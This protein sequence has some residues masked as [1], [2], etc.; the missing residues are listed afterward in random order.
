MRLIDLTG[1]TFGDLTVV[2][3]SA[4]MYGVEATWDCRCSCGAMIAVGGTRLRRGLT[5]HCGCKTQEKVQAPLTN[6]ERAAPRRRHITVQPG[7]Q[8]GALTV[9]EPY[10]KQPHRLT[11]WQCKCACGRGV[12]VLSTE[13]TSGLAWSC[14]KCVRRLY[15]GKLLRDIALR[16]AQQVVDLGG[17][18]EADA[19]KVYWRAYVEVLNDYHKQV[20]DY[21]AGLEGASNGLYN[22][23]TEAGDGERA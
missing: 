9:V 23:L 10:D 7:M 15:K 8:F 22:Y 2:G 6:I 5:T 12:R 18:P 20:N 14:G 13:L 17:A 19:D 11:V 21:M 3:R 1:K 4:A 16:L